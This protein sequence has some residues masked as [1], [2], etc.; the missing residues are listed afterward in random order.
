MSS[1]RW[2]AVDSSELL[3]HGDRRRLCSILA[4]SGS[5]PISVLAERLVDRAGGSTFDD[6]TAARI[7]LRHNHLPRLRDR[8]IVDYEPGDE[9]VSITDQV[10]FEADDADLVTVVY[11]SHVA[12]A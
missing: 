1:P 11:G 4:A 12:G 10:T 5:L 2:P 9:F 3:T 6:P 8:G 7:A